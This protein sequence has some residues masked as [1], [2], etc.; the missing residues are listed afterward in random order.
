MKRLFIYLILSSVICGCSFYSF[1]PKGRS[2]IS[3]ISIERFKN[4]TNEFGLEDQMTDQI[5]DALI[6]DGNLKIVPV[7]NAEAVLSGTLTTYERKP[8]NPDEND[9]VESYSIRMLFNI[10]LTNRADNTAIWK[11][12]INRIG[13]YNLETETEEDGQARAIQLLVDDIVEKTTKSW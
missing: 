7:E 6:A 4:N 11:D 10:Q 9:Q 12:N 1:S 8:Y 13:I 2:T 5:I 3:S